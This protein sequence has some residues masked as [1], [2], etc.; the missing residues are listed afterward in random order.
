MVSLKNLIKKILPSTYFKVEEEG[1]KVQKKLKKDLK[2]MEER[3]KQVEKNTKD[4]AAIQKTYVNSMRSLQRTMEN[5][6]VVLKDIL[7]T[8]TEKTN[9]ILYHQQQYMQEIIEKKMWK[10]IEHINRAVTDIQTNMS[11]VYKDM[12]YYYYKGLHPDQYEENLKEWFYKKTGEEADLENPTTYNE[13]I[14]WLKLNASTPKKS[15]LADKYLVRDYVKEKVGEKYLIPLLG[16]WENPDDINFDELPDRFALKVNHGAAWNIIVPDKKELNVAEAKAKLK[17]WLG[18]NFAFSA[19]LELQYKD[20]KPLVIAEEYLENTDGELN[21]YKIFCFNGE[22]K[23][24]M[25]LADRKNHLKMAFYDREWNKLPFVYTYDRLEE[26]IEKPDNLEEMLTL[27]EKLSEG[28]SQVRVDLYRLN[29]GTIK[30]GEMTF[31]CFS[32]ICSWDPPEY[33]KILGDL[34]DLSKEETCL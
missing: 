10:D 30:F 14:Q 12:E 21:D 17:K 13:K 29:D 23:Y 32:G 31:T 1:T 3:L 22:A 25:Y 2:R 11:G 4:I 26:T 24:I 20:I 33:N 15:E 19:G 7:T 6:M 28:F 8:K 18:I 9:A 34:I 27:A 16:V 5:N